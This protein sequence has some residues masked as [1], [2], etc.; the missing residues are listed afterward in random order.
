MIA[1]QNGKNRPA[2]SRLFVP[3]KPLK[4]NKKAQVGQMGQEN[5]TPLKRPDDRRFPIGGYV[6]CPICPTLEIYNEYNDLS[7]TEKR[8]KGGT[9]VP[10][11]KEI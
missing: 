11:Q 2:L 10:P 5:K 3:P 4:M 7:G 8:D 1:G 6:S 9:G